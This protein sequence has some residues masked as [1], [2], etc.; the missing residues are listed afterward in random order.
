MELVKL[1]G[2]IRRLVMTGA[3][4]DLDGLAA[5]ERQAVRA[6]ARRLGAVG[7]RVDLLAPPAGSL[8]WWSPA[9]PA[10]AKDSA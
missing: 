8:E 7:G 1:S 2:V 4:G 6:L 9:A 10:A 3:M 5:S